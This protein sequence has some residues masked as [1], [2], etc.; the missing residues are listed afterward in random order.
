MP[1][2]LEHKIK[3]QATVFLFTI[4]EEEETRA[5]VFES[6]KAL[7]YVGDTTHY[8]PSFNKVCQKIAP[9]TSKKAT[10]RFFAPS[11]Q[12]TPQDT[13]ETLNS[14][15]LEANH[16]HLLIF[17]KGYCDSILFNEKLTSPLDFFHWIT[18]PNLLELIP[19]DHGLVGRAQEISEAPPNWSPLYAKALNMGL[20][21][22]DALRSQ[23][24]EDDSA[25]AAAPSIESW[26]VAKD[27]LEVTAFKHACILFQT[28]LQRSILLSDDQ[29][30]LPTLTS[31]LLEVVGCTSA[32]HNSANPVKK[33]K[34]VIQTQKALA[35][36]L[37][38]EQMND[39]HEQLQ[40]AITTYEE[41]IKSF[42]HD[43]SQA[44]MEQCAIL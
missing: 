21:P 34:K 42:E 40:T 10:Y 2:P 18:Q 37:Q 12:D 9:G 26:F 3:H 7:F 22:Q 32:R 27:T 41:T 24:D 43:R 33:L 36:F 35:P 20:N 38:V 14:G 19:Q 31:E 1:L 44:R 29:I 39:H 16:E 30:K 28:E 23:T 25:A 4:N 13:W 5:Q 17:A 11:P 15:N 6:L 8:T